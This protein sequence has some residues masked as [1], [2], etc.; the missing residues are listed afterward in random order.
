[1]SAITKIYVEYA[2]HVGFFPE[3]DVREVTSRDVAEAKKNLSAR[4]FRFRFFDQ[5]S[6]VADGEELEGKPK[7]YSGSY[8]P[9]AKVWTTE[10]LKSAGKDRTL[11]QNSENY[12]GR[13]VCC[14]V[15][16][17]QPFQNG[18]QLV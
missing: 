8:Y 16:N 13:L 9:D 10:E 2:L 6:T 14:N 7:N 11:V 5:T 1:M 4:A 12:D 18:D 3:Y 17:W 15:G